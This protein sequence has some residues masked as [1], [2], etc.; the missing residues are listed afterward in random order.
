MTIIGVPTTGAI[1]VRVIGSIDNLILQRQPILPLYIEG[2]LVYDA[3][4]RIVNYALKEHA[5]LLFLDSDIAFD[6]SDYDK[7]VAHNTDIVCGL[8][9]GRTEDHKVPVAYKKVK[10]KNLL[11]PAIVENIDAKSMSDYME[12]E[13]AGLGFCL[14]KNKVLRS[15]KKNVNPFEP[16]GAL[17]EDLSFFIRCRKLGFKIMLD[18]TVNLQHIGQYAYSRKDIQC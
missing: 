7:L 4:A 10:P 8:Y 9:C 2:S 16:F 17:G 5:D 14:I 11:H 1:P 18:T 12:V 6:V 3:R 13:G 15:L